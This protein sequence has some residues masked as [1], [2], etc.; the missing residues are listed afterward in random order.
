MKLTTRNFQSTIG[1]TLQPHHCELPSGKSMTVPNEAY[2]VRE[3]FSMYRANIGPAVARD[4]KFDPAAD[5]D[6]DDLEKLHHLDLAELQEYKLR[7]LEEMKANDEKVKTMKS[8]ASA[9]RK[10]ELEELEEIKAE[11]RERKRARS[12]A[13]SRASGSTP[14]ED[15]R[16]ED[17]KGV[18]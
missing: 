5:F 10:A 15:E 1:W 11:L 16:M 17:V 13:S 8:E 18:D 12:Q 2:T 7:L 9:K 14:F 4:P 3:I 6:S